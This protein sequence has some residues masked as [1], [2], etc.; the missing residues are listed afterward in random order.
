MDNK[1]CTVCKIEK[2]TKNLHKK[3]SECK[4]CNIKREVRRNYHKK[5]KISFQQKIYYE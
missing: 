1:T 2:I 5:D 3:D 4:D